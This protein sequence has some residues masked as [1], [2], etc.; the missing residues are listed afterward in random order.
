[1]QVLTVD[2]LCLFFQSKLGTL[3]KSFHV[4]L[5]LAA[6]LVDHLN[7]PFNW[8]KLPSG[9]CLRNNSLKKTRDTPFYVDLWMFANSTGYR[10][11]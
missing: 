10:L 5:Y 9:I 4:A 8:A 6:H 7:Q 3:L 1:M 2:F 11:L